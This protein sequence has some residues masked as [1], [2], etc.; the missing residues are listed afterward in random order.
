MD[1][2]NLGL[3]FV[4][5]SA[6]LLFASAAVRRLSIG[7][8]AGALGVALLVLFALTAVFDNVMIA[9]GLF[10]YG[11]H[12]LLGIRVGLAPLEDFLYPLCT[13]LLMPALWWLLGGPARGARG[14]RQ[15]EN[16]AE[17]KEVG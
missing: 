6:L 15:A 11:E 1:F 4:G 9:V 7:R 2:L 14:A 8:V 17:R 16:L 10:D 3:W 13:V 5:G 12:A